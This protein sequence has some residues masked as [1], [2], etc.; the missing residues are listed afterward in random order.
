MTAP[1]F[2]DPNRPGHYPGDLRYTGQP[3]YGS[4]WGYGGQ[5]PAARPPKSRIVAGVLGLFLGWCGV[6]RFYLGFPGIG[7]AQIAVTVVTLGVGGLWGFIEGILYLAGVLGV[8]ATGRR[9]GD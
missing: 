7:V 8:D 4:N 6:H 5:P 2:H 1:G 9:L 3:Q